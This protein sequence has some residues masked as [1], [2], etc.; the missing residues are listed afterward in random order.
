MYE[1]IVPYDFNTLEYVSIYDSSFKLDNGVF[2]SLVKYEYI[3][4]INIFVLVHK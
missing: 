2:R 4:I 1:V 3:I